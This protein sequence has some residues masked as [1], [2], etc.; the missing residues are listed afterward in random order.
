[1]HGH[2][3]TLLP[4]MKLHD[5]VYLPTQAFKTQNT[6]EFEAKLKNPALFAIELES[7]DDIEDLFIT[8]GLP[9]PKV[10]HLVT[11]LYR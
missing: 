8:G 10:F 7:L 9:K 5:C 3:M 6:K 11:I 4:N 1:M 2:A